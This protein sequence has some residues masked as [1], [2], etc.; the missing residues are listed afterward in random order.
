MIHLILWLFLGYSCL[1]ATTIR[2]CYA[3]W[4]QDPST[5]I[6]LHIHTQD[7]VGELSIDYAPCNGPSAT[8]QSPVYKIYRGGRRLYHVYLNHLDPNTTYYCTVREGDH[9]L[10]SYSF[11]TLPL[12]PPY[13]FIDAGDWENTPVA[14]ELAQVAATYQPDAVWLGGDYPSEVYSVKDMPLWDQWLDGYAI[15]FHQPSHHLTPMVVAI[16]NHEVVGGFG[17]PRE[18]AFFYFDWFRPGQV[19]YFSLPLGTEAQ[20]IVLDSGH[21]ATHGGDQKVW[22]E[23]TLHAAETKPY[24]IALY[25]VP[26]YPGVRFTEKNWLFH[27]LVACCGWAQIPQAERRLFSHPSCWGQTH[28]LPLF[29]AYHLTVAFE[30]HD[31]CLKRTY[32]LQ[33]NQKHPQGTVYLGDGGFGAATQWAPIKGWVDPLYAK[34]KG[35]QPCFWLIE[36]GEQQLSCHAITLGHRQL[37]ECRFRAQ[38]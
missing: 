38:R 22:L 14:K 16:G 3:T 9:H 30:H 13:R 6:S 31:Q 11:H 5:T 7:G 23:N 35:K 18:H 32:P 25:H 10:G 20:L 27:R 1:H 36:M 26:L 34:V 8:L 37:D 21:V 17:Q 15:A 12:H 2:H 24:R 28:W 29:D 19:S 33:N 4:D